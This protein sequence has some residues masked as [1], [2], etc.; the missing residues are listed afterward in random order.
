MDF[1]VGSGDEIE[2][3][4]LPALEQLVRMGYQYKSKSEL[5]KERVRLD[6]VLLYDRLE[7][8]IRRLNPHIDQDGISDALSQIKEDKFPFAWDTVDTNEKIRAKLVGLSQSGGLDPITVEQYDAT[9]TVRKTIRLFDF[10]NMQNN[11]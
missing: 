5:N 7:K 9:R 2:H 8:A 11:D 4:E 6:E 10:E 1:V 3:S